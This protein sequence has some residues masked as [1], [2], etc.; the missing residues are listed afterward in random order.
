MEADKKTD[1][2]PIRFFRANT[3]AINAN[4]GANP[5]PK[6]WLMLSAVQFGFS[7]NCINIQYYCLRRIRKSSDYV[8]TLE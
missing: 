3:V 2:V 4:N 8:E 5:I 7:F 1:P 6:A